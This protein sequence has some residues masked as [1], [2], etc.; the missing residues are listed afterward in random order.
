MVSTYTEM[1]RR[2]YGNVLDEKA[3]QYL[4]YVTEGSA[5]MHRLLRD[6]RAFTHVATHSSPAPEVDANAVLRETLVNLKIA[7]DESGAEV[8]C[9]HLPTVCVHEFQLE[10]L[11]QNLIGNAIHYRRDAAPRIEIN[12]EADG[13]FWKFFIQDNGIG[14]AAEYKE[15]IFGM[16]KRLH[17]AAEY[18]G[19]GMGLAICQRIVEGSGG[20]IWV[21]SELGSGSIFYFTLPAAK[22][23]AGEYQRVASTNS[24]G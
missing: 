2:K 21:E 23:Y 4:G 15:Q 18:S 19:S 7:L 8:I 13:D 9:G 20:R 14:I 24:L 22:R 5:R 16:F 3:H 17:T 1:L 10:Q 11:F 12:A 6:L